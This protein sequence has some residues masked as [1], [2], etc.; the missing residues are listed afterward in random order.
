MK[1][2]FKDRAEAVKALEEVLPTGKM[3]KD[4]WKLVAVSKEGVAIASLLN[5]RRMLDIEWLMGEN[6]YAPHNPDCELG[7]ISENEALVINDRLLDVFDIQ[8]DYVYGEARRKHEERILSKIYHFR[9]GKPLGNM[10]GQNVLLI[11]QGV[12]TG[13]I[14]L[15]AIKTV[16]EMKPN[17]L[18]VAAPVM[19]APVF[20]MIDPLCDAVYSPYI[21]DDYIETSCYYSSMEPIS[22]EEIIKLLGV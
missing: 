11:D 7:R 4:Q 5:R 21:L 8:Y 14:V 2:V 16:L 17:A 15:C 13:M 22:D 12:Q 19:P 6:I 10:K 9:K 20:E 18:Y 1:V 3:L